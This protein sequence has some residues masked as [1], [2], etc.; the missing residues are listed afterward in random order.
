[1]VLL[2]TIYSCR[3]QL[4]GT[5][6]G[7]SAQPYDL[8]LV[9]LAGLT[10]IGIFS[11]TASNTVATRTINGTQESS[12]VMVHGISGNP[13]IDLVTTTVLQQVIIIRNP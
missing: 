3:L 13:T 11:R 2:L 6:E 4:D 10:I 9:A 5:N 1:M 8:D 7:T 12:N